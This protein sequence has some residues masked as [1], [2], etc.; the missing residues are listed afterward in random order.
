ML[1]PQ[2]YFLYKSAL[3]RSWGLA[4]SMYRQ[5]E[6]VPSYSIDQGERRERIDGKIGERRA[7]QKLALRARCSCVFS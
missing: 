6:C 3:V 1:G 2:D 7:V 4:L 5:P